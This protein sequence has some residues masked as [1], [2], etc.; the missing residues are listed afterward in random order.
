MVMHVLR[1]K[2]SSGGELRPIRPTVAEAMANPRIA[3][4]F[5]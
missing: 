3:P 2:L 1:N 4:G 5:S